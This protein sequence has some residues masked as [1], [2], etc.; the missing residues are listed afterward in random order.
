MNN[1][2]DCGS[3]AA[4]ASA[5]AGVSAPITAPPPATGAISPESDSER[6]GRLRRDLNR[7]ILRIEL[8]E[9]HVHDSSGATC[10][11]AAETSRMRY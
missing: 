2:C 11:R 7:L 6:I 3:V 5:Y 1:N 10:I 4:A 9:N 8:L